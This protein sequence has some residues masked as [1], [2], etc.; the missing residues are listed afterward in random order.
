MKRLTKRDG[1][2]CQNVCGQ[3]NTC[4]K[5]KTSPA[6]CKDAQNYERLRQYENTGL[7]PKEVVR[8]K[9]QYARVIRETG[10]DVEKEKPEP[11]ERNPYEREALKYQAELERVQEKLVWLHKRKEQNFALKETIARY[12]EM[13]I[14]MKI[15]MN[16]VRKKAARDQR[17]E[18]EENHGGTTTR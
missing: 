7:S 5:L 15:T 14:E 6:P 12:E 2:Y 16:N 10:P 4:Q 9:E 11:I 13:A 3:K 18:A 8:M 1:D 17:C